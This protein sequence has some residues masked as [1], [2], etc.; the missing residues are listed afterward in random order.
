M[1]FADR[2]NDLVSKYEE[3]GKKLLEPN[4]TGDEIVKLSKENSNLEPIV[5]KIKEYQGAEQGLL[6]CEE[7]LKEENDSE[8]KKMIEEEIGELRKKL[9]IL[10]R[11]VEL[12]LLPKDEADEKNAILEI[13]AGTGGEEAS[14]FGGVLF[15]M[16]QRYAEKMGWKFE[17][18]SIDESDLGGVKEASISIK[19]HNVFK[20][21]KFESGCHRVQRVPETEQKG[22]VHTSA[23]TVAVL[24]EAEEV[25]IKIE[26]KDLRIDICRASGPGGQ[27]V[28]TTDSAVRITHLP[29]GIVVQQQDER[30][31]HK[32]MDK[33]MKILRSKLYDLERSKKDKERAENRKEQIG[34]GDR[35]DKIRTYNYPQGRVTDHRINLTLYKLD[36]ITQEGDLDELIDALIT[37][38][39]AKKLANSDI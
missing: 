3:V 1:S 28:N 31:Q 9:P 32:N 11:E 30:S 23:A 39:E 38:E 21:L 4:L 35:S 12:M 25:D 29:T 2:L 17:V 34:T 19:G 26:D 6:D 36:Q 16:Y 7:M 15:K 37:D 18:M 5:N 14:L 10:K 13:R 27:G 24:P 33:A 8:T 22:R 20:R